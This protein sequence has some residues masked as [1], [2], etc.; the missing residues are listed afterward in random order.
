LLLLRLVLGA[1]RADALAD[2]A[3]GVVEDLRRLAPQLALLRLLARR[4]DQGEQRVA[5]AAVEVGERLGDL[6]AD[7]GVAVARDE[8][9]LLLEHLLE[10]LAPLV[11]VGLAVGLV[12]VDVADQRLALED[13]GRVV[14]VLALDREAEALGEVAVAGDR[15]R[16]AEVDVV[17]AGEDL[18]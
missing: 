13:L 10:L 3:L 18:A 2:E 8:V 12:E 16:A 15:E 6:L 17:A 11:A 7:R 14:R 4:V 5:D 9:A 1:H